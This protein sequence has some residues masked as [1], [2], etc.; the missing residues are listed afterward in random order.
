[1]VAEQLALSWLI[2]RMSESK[3]SIRMRFESRSVGATGAESKKESGWSK[4][5][6]SS[7]LGKSF[8]MELHLCVLAALR[9]NKF[10]VLAA[11]RENN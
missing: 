7:I 5:G 3:C 2:E 4:P 11:L 10:C 6:I 9:E 1:M 8:I